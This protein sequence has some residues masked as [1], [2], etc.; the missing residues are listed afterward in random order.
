[1]VTHG[2]APEQLS[3][4]TIIPIV[5]NKRKSVNDINNYR[6][7]ALSS[8][9]GK[10]IDLI[11]LNSQSNQLKC[12]ELQFGFTKRMSTT[13]CTF[14]AEETINYYMKNKSHVFSV[15]LDASKAFDRV[16]YV[17]L[18]RLLLKRDI[19]PVIARFLAFMYTNNQCR[20]KWDG[21]LSQA[22]KV[23]NGVRQG[24]VLSPI[25][26]NVY[27]DVLLCK[28]KE[29]ELGCH[30]GSSFAGAL[31]YADDVLLLCPSMYAVKKMISVC[32]EFSQAF[33]IQ[34]NASK[35]KLLLFGVVE[36][37]I[38]QMQGP[39]ECVKSEKHLGHIISTTGK[40]NEERIRHT[41]N[42]LYGKFNLMMAQFSNAQ[43][44][45]KYCLFKSFCMSMYGSNLW[46]LS[47]KDMSIIFVAWRKCIRRLLDLS[48]RAHSRLLH[49]LC[50]DAPVDIQIHRRF[51]K[52]FTSCY[53]SSNKLLALASKL[54]LNG[55]RSG[56]CNSLN[57]VCYTYNLDKISLVNHP[58]YIDH[59]VNDA[60]LQLVYRIQDFLHLR[61]W[62]CGE[63]HQLSDIIN[64]LCCE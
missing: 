40:I 23:K 53:Q 58:T 42:E 49:L 64:Y 31:A 22:F 37:V 19:C 39:I 14:L 55:S 57:Y 33:N 43:F 54:V 13:Q 9:L 48:P 1:M 50:D 20:I 16:H 62:L 38:V 61:F 6:G 35:S 59:T 26:F 60:D 30:I 15:F 4:A 36:H 51:V 11:I 27:I 41:A 7:I 3:L 32:E 46:D 56:T 47:S 29:T 8:V 17:K 5:K 2:Y 25:L 12:S 24:G 63:Y 28:L 10:V 45:V 44:N 21:L 18:F 34:F 52:F